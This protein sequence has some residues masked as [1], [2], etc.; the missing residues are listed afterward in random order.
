MSLPFD[1]RLLAVPAIVISAGIASPTAADSLKVGSDAPDINALDWVQGGVTGF[2]D[3][4]KTY[5]VE[6]WA[7]WCGPCMRSIPHLNELHTKYRAKGLEII[8]ISDEPLSTVRPFV[9][10]KGAAMSYAVACDRDKATNEK[11]MK[12][13]GQ[14]GIPCAFIVRGGKIRWIGNPLD[15]KFDEVLLGV[16][17]GRYS[18]ELMAKAEPVLK[19][20]RDA[21]KLKNF[22]D[23]YKHYDAVIALDPRAFGDVAVRKY[24]VMLVDAKDKAAADQWAATMLT[25]LCVNDANTATDLAELILNDDAITDRDFKTALAAAQQADLLARSASSK[26]LVALAYHRM[27]E[28][29]KASELQYEAWMKAE[30]AEKADYR[31]VLDN[32]KKAAPAAAKTGA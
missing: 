27:G 5:V 16:I 21:A 25:T 15:P 1:L 17:S 30:P 9:N 23:A 14:N 2:S 6:F 29:G 32:Y 22:R 18:P 3:D 20:A 11:W 12:A 10:K 4:R 19:A 13:A 24:R 8:G 28:T 26:A 31:K 7:T